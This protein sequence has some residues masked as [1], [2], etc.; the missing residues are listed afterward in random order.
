MRPH[1]DID[2]ERALTLLHVIVEAGKHGPMF[3]K[4]LS[5]AQAEL[6][7]L[8]DEHPEP[9]TVTPA[10]GGDPVLNPLEDE[11]ELNQETSDVRR[12]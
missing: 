3:Q 1:S 11:S 7:D 5:A 2:Y 12:I 9:K 8:L 4:L 6:R 10:D